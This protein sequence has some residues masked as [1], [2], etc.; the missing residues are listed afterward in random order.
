MSFSVL[1]ARVNTLRASGR[2]ADRSRSNCTSA[3]TWSAATSIVTEDDAV[4]PRPSSAI[5]VSTTLPGAVCARHCVVA[6]RVSTIVP[7]VTDQ[8]A[9]T[10]SPSGS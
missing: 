7:D 3:N 6:A 9:F 10:T 2:I 4:P 1:S 8:R 5:T